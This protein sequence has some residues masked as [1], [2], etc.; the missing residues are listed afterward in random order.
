MRLAWE[1][2]DSRPLT[3]YARMAYEHG[4]ITPTGLR[5]D[6]LVP[7]QEWCEENRCGVRTSF[8]MFKFKNEKEMSIFLLKWG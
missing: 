4:A 5:E 2:Y 6:H 1:K 8:D 7:V 3:L